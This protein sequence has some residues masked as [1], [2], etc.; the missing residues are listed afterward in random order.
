[1]KNETHKSVSLRADL[2]SIIRHH[3]EAKSYPQG[4][5]EPD[6]ALITTALLT[7]H[8]AI[9]EGNVR[10]PDFGEDKE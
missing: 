9:K 8:H 5:M 3:F 4:A 1:M 6:S 7:L 10:L 2:V